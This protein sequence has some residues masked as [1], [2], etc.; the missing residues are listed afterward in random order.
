MDH[1]RTSHAELVKKLESGA[2]M[3]DATL[4]EL[5]QAISGFARTVR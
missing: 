5:N 3:E 1:L 2:R 4:N